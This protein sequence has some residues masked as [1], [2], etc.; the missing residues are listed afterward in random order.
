MTRAYRF[1]RFRVDLVKHHVTGPDGAVLAIA[2]RAYEALLY[3]IENRARLVGKDDLLKAVWPRAVVEENN[4]NQAI[5]ALRR[6][7]GDT[8]EASADHRHR[9]RPRLSLCRGSAGRDGRGD[10][11]GA[12]VA[13][14]CRLRMYRCR[15]Q[16]PDIGDAWQCLL[17][18][19]TRRAS[20]AAARAALA[21]LRAAFDRR[22]VAVPATL[23]AAIGGTV[24]LSCGR[25][26]RVVV[27]STAGQVPSAAV[28]RRTAVQAT[29]G[30]GW[31]RGTRV[32]YR[33]DADQP[34]ERPARRHGDPVEFRAQVRRSQP[35]PARRRPRARR[36][37]GHRGSRPVP[38][39][40]HPSHGAPARR[41]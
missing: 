17:R 13:G 7:L 19:I 26:R 27:A 15:R 36:R 14:N 12:G 4:L 40:S 21:C 1:D 31:R 3:L 33:G 29:G 34:T 37:R 20:D 24:A 5:S 22:S 39:G 23:L 9:A 2:S 16:W 41:T 18:P 6:A 30:A 38:A 25:N 32:R 28:D 11:V 10:P 8:R 35:G